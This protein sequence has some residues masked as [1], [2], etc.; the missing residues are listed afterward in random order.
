MHALASVRGVLPVFAVLGCAAA[1]GGRPA[2]KRCTKPQKTERRSKLVWFV[3]VNFAFGGELKINSDQF[4]LN[5]TQLPSLVGESHLRTTIRSI[6]FQWR[7]LS[8]SFKHKSH[9]S[10]GITLSNCPSRAVRVS[11]ITYLKF[12]WT[13]FTIWV[14]FHWHRR[15]LPSSEQPFSDPYS[16]RCERL[17]LHI[18]TPTFLRS[19]LVYIKKELKDLV[20]IS[21]LLF[22]CQ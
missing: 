15:S 13:S 10:S 5:R 7:F 12:V 19:F 1:F 9:I 4:F 21:Y 6:I 18:S 11:P 22:L 8:R 2:N 17:R 20:Q 3:K 16:E 14:T